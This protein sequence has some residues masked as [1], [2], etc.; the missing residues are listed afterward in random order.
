M[1]K[2]KRRIQHTCSDAA[3]RDDRQKKGNQNE[4]AARYQPDCIETGV[5]QITRVN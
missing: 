5:V 4:K 3:I 2:S 1:V